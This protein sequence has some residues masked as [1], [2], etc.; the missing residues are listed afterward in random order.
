MLRHSC[1]WTQRD[2]RFAALFRSSRQGLPARQSCGMHAVALLNRNA[3]VVMSAST[4]PHSVGP[5]ETS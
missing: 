5:G 2:G 3:E 4:H 1:S